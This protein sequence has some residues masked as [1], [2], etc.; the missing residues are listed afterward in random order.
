[1]WTPFS[2]RGRLCIVQAQQEARALGDHHIGTEHLLLAVLSAA[3]GVAARAGESLGLNVSELRSEVE[4]QK[5]QSAQSLAKTKRLKKEDFGFDRSSKDAIEAL[6]EE[7]RLRGKKSLTPELLLLAFFRN[8]N[9][10][11]SKLLAGHGVDRERAEAAMRA[12]DPD[13]V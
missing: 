2:E 13:S 9:S 6:F 11:A 10:S 12:I 5:S 7:S 4:G 1:M 8:P 3:D